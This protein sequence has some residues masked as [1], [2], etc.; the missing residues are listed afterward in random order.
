MRS[1]NPNGIALF[2]V[3]WVLTLL[4]VMVA[5][6]AFATRTAVNIVRNFK[7]ETQ[8]YYLA[9]SGM[10]R[11]VAD[12]LADQLAPG[13][14]NRTA[15]AETDPPMAFPPLSRNV[16]DTI[17]FPGG[18]ARIEF[19]SLSG[20][21]NINRAG[22]RLLA[23]MLT[24]FELDQKTTAIIVDSIMDW[25]DPDHLHRINGAENAYYRGLSEPYSAKNGDFDTPA[26]LLRVRGVT[27]EIYYG[28]LDEMV[29]VFPRNDPDENREPVN[30]KKPP[31][32]RVD[33]DR[34]DINHIGH[35][36]LAALPGMT[37]ETA[38][39]VLEQRRNERFQGVEALRPI[40]GD[41]AFGEVFHFLTVSEIPV[42]RIRSMGVPSNTRVRHAIEAVVE[43]NP[44]DRNP[45]R[46]LQWRKTAA[47][48]E[49]HA[50]SG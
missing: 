47:A 21:V 30:G 39:A 29:A 49:S 26:E 46:F 28:G 15:S 42:Y 8:A 17:G 43:V 36:L 16:P 14:R 35:T 18:S 5:E 9:R 6:F 7:E 32:A 13:R 22:P 10:N 2:I 38:D 23:A 37:A 12:L 1:G 4:S 40:L 44:T 27:P 24:S 34:I 41:E 20:K 33:F 31:Y 48:G 45:Y 19:Q 25:R 3:L 11:A 50:V